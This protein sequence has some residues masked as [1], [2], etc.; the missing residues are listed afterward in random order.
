MSSFENETF[1]SSFELE[2]I[3]FKISDDNSTT[4]EGGRGNDRKI[5][6]KGGKK[7]HLVKN[8]QSELESQTSIKNH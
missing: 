7:A 3:S 2:N 5:T 8:L 6:G 4:G 1:S